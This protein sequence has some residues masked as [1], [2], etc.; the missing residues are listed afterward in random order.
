MIDETIFCIHGGISQYI[1]ELN[2]IDQIERYE[3]IQQESA[4]YDLVWSDPHPEGK[5]GWAKSE[6]GAGHYFGKEEVD[7]FMTTNNV[8]LICR[9]HQ[10]VKA[11][12]KYHFNEKKI[13]TV[14][15]APNYCYWNIN[16]ASILKL[17]DQLNQKFI[18]FKAVAKN[19]RVIPK[20]ISMPM[21]L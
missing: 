13:V 10:L 11:G 7:K 19:K 8:S 9:A 21:F 2:Q 12:W 4:F 15:S 20:I 18:T 3:E 5:N 1:S 14:W 17:D 16:D 6:R